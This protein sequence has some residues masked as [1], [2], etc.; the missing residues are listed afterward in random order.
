MQGWASAPILPILPPVHAFSVHERG[1]HGDSC[2]LLHRRLKGIFFQNHKIGQHPG[3]PEKEKNA[4]WLQAR[5]GA[6]QMGVSN[7]K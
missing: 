3:A 6:K 4:G 7:E 2:D 5:A 1:Q